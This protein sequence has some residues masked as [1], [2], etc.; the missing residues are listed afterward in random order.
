MSLETNLTTKITTPGAGSI[1]A[2]KYTYEVEMTITGGGGG[3]G[4]ATGGPR[5]TNNGGGGASGSLIIKTISLSEGDT[6]EYAVGAGG[7][8]GSSGN[9]G[10]LSYVKYNEISYSSEGGGGGSNGSSGGGGGQSSPVS[11]G[12]TNTEGNNGSHGPFGGGG[13]DSVSSD[14]Y[15]AGGDGS[16]SAIV[17][18]NGPGGDGG[19]VFIFKIR[20]PGITVPSGRAEAIKEARIGGN[21]ISLTEDP[22][23]GKSRMQASIANGAISLEDTNTKLTIG[24]MPLTLKQTS[25]GNYVIHVYVI[26]DDTETYTPDIFEQST[27]TTMFRGIDIDTFVANDGKR[28]FVFDRLE[29]QEDVSGFG[30]LNSNDSI[31]NTVMWL[32]VPTVVNNDNVFVVSVS[33]SPNVDEFVTTYF[34]GFP[35]LVARQGSDYLLCALFD[36]YTYESEVPGLN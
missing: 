15:G 16:T 9:K 23:T 1:E 30:R 2:P 24:G 31:K 20:T 36:D 17:Q 26:D 34:M 13:G 10:G 33:D 5:G 29:D 8:E 11:D 25:N 19:I 14:G 27:D 22:L 21:R 32:G 12:D 35:F 7:S 6:L 18:N 4:E 3:G 28:V